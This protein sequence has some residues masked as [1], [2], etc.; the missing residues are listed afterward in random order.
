MHGTNNPNGPGGSYFYVHVY[1]YA[2]DGGSVTQVAIPYRQTNGTIYFRDRYTGAWTS[3]Y[4]LARGDGKGASGTWGIDITGNAA[5]ADSVDGQNFEWH[6]PGGLPYYFWGKTAYGDNNRVY[7]TSRFAPAHSHPYAATSHGSHVGG[8][9]SSVV[10]TTSGGNCTIYHSYG[11]VLPVVCNGDAS[12]QP[13]GLPRVYN[14][15]S[16]GFTLTGMQANGTC[17]IN[18]MAMPG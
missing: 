8:Y 11:Q 4:A 1:Q 18:W 3:W 6:D 16:G 15:W 5:T 13:S 10:S 9:G 2:S 7:A 17:R 12:A 14:W